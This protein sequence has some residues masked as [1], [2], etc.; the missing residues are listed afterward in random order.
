MGQQRIH[1]L[2]CV[3]LFEKL[4]LCGKDPAKMKKKTADIFFTLELNEPK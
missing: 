4:A 2:L 3:Y 1:L